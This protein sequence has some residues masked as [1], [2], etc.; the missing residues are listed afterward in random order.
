MRQAFSPQSWLREKSAD[1]PGN[2]MKSLPMID[3]LLIVCIH[4]GY[5]WLANDQSNSRVAETA[6]FLTSRKL[7]EYRVAIGEELEASCSEDLY[8]FELE[9]AELGKPIEE[10]RALGHPVPAQATVPPTPPVKRIAQPREKMKWCDW[11]LAS[12]II[13]PITAA[14]VIVVFVVITGLTGRS[15]AA[16][17]AIPP[18]ALPRPE[19]TH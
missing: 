3:C 17:P 14:I 4:V 10:R 11:I 12:I 5:T 7:P 13:G 18:M 15:P 8:R 19:T 9:L 16:D 2:E 1:E 6:Q